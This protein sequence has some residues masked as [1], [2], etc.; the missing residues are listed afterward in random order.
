MREIKFRAWDKEK[1]LM[2]YVF[3][4]QWWNHHIE[5]ENPE[6]IKEIKTART[7]RI[8]P[9]DFELM[10]YTGLKDKNGKE[11]YSKDIINIDGDEKNYEVNFHQG[12]FGIIGGDSRHYLLREFV[13]TGTSVSERCIGRIK[14]IGNKFD[15]PELIKKG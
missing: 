4:I 8:F 7:N 1:K 10:Q 6:K 3:G 5:K 14:I 12:C 13:S 15:N 9:G 2:L 11:I